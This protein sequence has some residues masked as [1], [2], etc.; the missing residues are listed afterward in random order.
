LLEGNI[1]YRTKTKYGT[2]ICT[3][4]IVRTWVKLKNYH[5]LNSGTYKYW[6]LTLFK[7]ESIITII[8]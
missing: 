7:L 6:E 8:N 4:A 5:M 3:G 1:S 2:A